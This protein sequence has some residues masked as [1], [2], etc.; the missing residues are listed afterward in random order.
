MATASSR[1]ITPAPNFPR[2]ISDLR[3][4]LLARTRRGY[5]QLSHL[6]SCARRAAA[7]GGYWVDRQMVEDNLPEECFA[8]WLPHS[9]NAAERHAC[10]AAW[11]QRIF[12]TNLRLGVQLHLQGDDRGELRRMTQ[13]GNRFGITLCAAGGVLMHEPS[14]RVLLDTLAAIRLGR[15]LDKLGYAGGVQT[16]SATCA[17]EVGLRSSIHPSCSTRR[18]A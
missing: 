2:S 13:L 9:A 14:R 8:L 1:R 15:P 12:G 11:L 18:C 6:I 16:T 17:I 3:V 7:K 4:V 5:G 10:Q